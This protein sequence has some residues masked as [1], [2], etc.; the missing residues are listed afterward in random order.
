VLPTIDLGPKCK[1]IGYRRLSLEARKK[2]KRYY[3]EI[4]D[5]MQVPQ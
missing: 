5:Q 3:M 2:G 4:Y 1:T